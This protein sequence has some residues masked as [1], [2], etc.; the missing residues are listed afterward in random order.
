MFSITKI[1]QYVHLC[2]VKTLLKIGRHLVCSCGKK[3]PAI[4]AVER[5][6]VALLQ[7]TLF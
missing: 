4:W 7:V 1:V 2:V 3:Q 5:A 6:Q